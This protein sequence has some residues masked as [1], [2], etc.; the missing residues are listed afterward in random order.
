MSGYS[1][2]VIEFRPL[3]EAPGATEVTVR[4]TVKRPGA[5]RTTIDYDME[6]SPAGWKVYDIKIA[7]VSLNSAYQPSFARTIRDGG[8]DGLIASL[9]AGN[10]QADAELKSRVSSAR[11]FLFFLYAVIPSLFHSGK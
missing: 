9:S 6:K 7:G 2:P 5:E 3:R 8:V 11:P 10:R 4:S 1:I